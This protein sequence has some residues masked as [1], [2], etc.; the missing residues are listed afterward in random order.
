MRTGLPLSLAVVL[1]ILG[2]SYA[3]GQGAPGRGGPPGAFGRGRGGPPRTPRAGALYD[4]TGYWVSV[5]SEDWRF[6]MVTPPKGDYTGVFLN[7][8]GRKVADSWDPAKDEAAGEQCRSYGAPALMRVPGHLRITWQ[9]EQTLR[10]ESDAG[11]QTR[12]LH[13]DAADTPGSAWQ[14]YSK[15]MWEMV[16]AGRGVNPVG[17]LKIVTTRLKPG[18]LRK[19]G[20][21][22]SANATLTEYFDRANEP[23]GQSYLVVTST[24]EDPVYLV[25]PFLTSSHYRKVADNSGW[26]PV[27]CAAK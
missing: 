15:A 17:S 9:D 8:E 12:I 26:K 22:Y 24:V 27:P 18:Y 23:N 4:I 5:V 6:R 21:P 19:N 20:V 7:Q 14:G 13:F 16:P 25:Q 2:V 10:I 1:T 3:Q 11:E